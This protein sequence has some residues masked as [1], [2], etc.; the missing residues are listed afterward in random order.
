[1]KLYCEKC[2]SEDIEQINTT[3]IIPEGRQ[4]IADF[5]GQPT[6]MTLEY[7]PQSWL[8]RCK[9]CGNNKE[10]TPGSITINSTEKIKFSSSN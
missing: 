7:R 8:V 6:V 3:P 2:N 5:N 4:S 10:I 9:N 1:M